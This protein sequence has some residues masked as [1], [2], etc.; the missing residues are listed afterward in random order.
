[1]CIY[2]INYYLYII[3]KIYYIYINIYYKV[4]YYYYNMSNCQKIREFMTNCQK[5]LM[6]YIKTR[7]RGGKINDFL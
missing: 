6:K 2:I 4:V 1:M 3:T 5:F 7:P